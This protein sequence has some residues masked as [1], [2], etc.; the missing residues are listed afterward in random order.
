M[1][2]HTQLLD[3]IEGL[4]GA[5]PLLLI[6]QRSLPECD[7]HIELS[8]LSVADVAQLWR[9]AGH[10]PTSQQIARLHEY[11]AGNPRLINLLLTLHEAGP[12]VIA[13][14]DS[15]DAAKSLLPAFQ[16]LWRRLM[17]EERRALQR[18]A[19]YQGYAP[20]SLLPPVT[21]DALTGLRLVERDGAGGIAPLPAFSAIVYDELSTELRERLH[22]EA[23][24]IRLERGEYTAA[25]YH[26]AR[27]NQESRAYVQTRQFHE[28]LAVGAPAYTFFTAVRDPYFAG[29]TGNNLAE[30]SFELGDLES[31]ARYAGE[32]LSLGHRSTVPYARFTLGQIDLA[33]GDAARAIDNFTD[34]MQIAQSNADPYL[35]A[36]AAR[37][38][39]QAYMAAGNRG[40][41]SQHIRSALAL[42]RQLDIP[43]EIATTEQLIAEVAG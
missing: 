30:A 26:F 10:D 2:A 15:D 34:S 20:E 29:H 42:F 24:I 4:R 6:S 19:V 32:V 33:H 12:D 14:L 27:S 28:A 25:V 1:P 38:L 41:A 5:T 35:V 21:L 31:A 18:L 3:L 22:S 9:A 16:R 23:A 8:G 40:A 37:S 36:Y 7:L 17:P 11:T 43:G 39:G 13:S